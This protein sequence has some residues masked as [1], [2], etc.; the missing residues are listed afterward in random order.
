VSGGGHT[1]SKATLIDPLMNL[2]PLI[3]QLLDAQMQVGHLGVHRVNLLDVRLDGLVE[4]SRQRV[5]RRFHSRRT[6]DPD[7]HTPAAVHHRRVARAGLSMRGVVAVRVLH[8]DRAA[9]GQHVLRCLR[10]VL[11]VFPEGRRALRVVV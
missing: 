9:V 6:L 3:L 8:R 4:R 10:A 2:R 1:G 11:R 5:R 7:A